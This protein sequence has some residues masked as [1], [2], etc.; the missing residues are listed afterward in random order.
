MGRLAQ[1]GIGAIGGDGHQQCC[2]PCIV[3]AVVVGGGGC[4]GGGGKGNNG[5]VGGG[6]C[7]RGGSIGTT[8]SGDSCGH[9]RHGGVG[10]TDVGDI[11]DFGGAITRRRTRI[12]GR[13]A[14]TRRRS[15]VGIT[16]LTCGICDFGGARIGGFT[17]GSRRWVSLA[18]ALLATSDGNARRLLRFLDRVL[19]RVGGGDR[20]GLTSAANARWLLRFLCDGDRSVGLACG[21]LRWGSMTDGGRGPT[22]IFFGAC[23][24]GPHGGKTSSAS[25]KY[26]KLLRIRGK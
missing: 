7:I 15:S 18:L 12:R 24:A 10:G 20:S 9:I 23:S 5:D 21:A 4:I 14:I 26:S 8:G 25:L 1:G 17:C 16:R 2:T 6:C 11:C 19:C 22:R 13:G 3:G